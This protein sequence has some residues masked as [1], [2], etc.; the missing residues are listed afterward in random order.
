MDIVIPKVN[1]FEKVIGVQEL[2]SEKK[3][4]FINYVVK[5]ECKNDIVIFNTLTRQLI[6]LSRQEYENINNNIR[7]LGYKKLVNDWFL[8]PDDFDELKFKEQCFSLVNLL[9]T[10]KGITNYV[11]MPT[12]DCNARCFYCFEHGAKKY[13]MTQKIA[14]DVADF[15][16]K[17]SF[18]QKVNI[19][20]F[21]GEPLYNIDAINIITNRFIENG[22]NFNSHMITNGYLF[23]EK[24]VLIA[25]E[26][27]NLNWVQITLDGTEEIYNKCKNYIYKNGESP[28]IIVINNIERLLRAN[29]SVSIR[30]NMDKH[31]ENDLYNL[32]DF[33]YQRF[34]QYKELFSIYVWLLY[35]NR[36]SVKK[37]RTDFERIEMIHKLN[38]LEN[39]IYEKGLGIPNFPA[40]EIKTHACLADNDHNTV[41]TPNG[42]LTKCD[43]HSDDEIWGNIYSDEIDFDVINRWKETIPPL[44]LCK[45]CPVLPQCMQLKMCSEYGARD[46]DIYLQEQRILK[47]KHRIRNVYYKYLENNDV[48]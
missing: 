20:W 33:L 43:H 34:S 10:K 14:Y 9:D 47:L 5:L 26:K 23:D 2:Y 1:L 11:I 8:V 42:N 25:K 15:I 28:F 13:S 44:E 37:I 12:M 41:I 48:S 29:I 46:C 22:Q 17:K 39:Y 3:Y 4:R 31:N 16:I 40:A 24:T 6:I 7:N 35:E 45:T 36:G 18:G 21:G 38:N 27:W 19:Q 32:V 30:I